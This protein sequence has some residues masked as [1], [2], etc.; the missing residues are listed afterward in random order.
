MGTTFLV[1]QA[2]PSDRRS[3]THVDE[4]HD[5]LGL[6]PHNLTNLSA[7]GGAPT[8]AVSQLLAIAPSSDTCADA[9][10]PSECT[11]TTASLAQI[12]IASF[13]RHSV[14][15]GLEQAALLSWMAFESAEWKYNRNHFPAPGR[16]GQGTRVMMMP[17]YVAEFASGFEELTD[18][19]TAAGGD[20]DRILD[21]VLGDEYSFAAAAWFYDTQCTQEVKEG[22]KT[23]GEQGW[24]EF[25]TGCVETTVTADRKGY[26]VR[27]CEALN[28]VVV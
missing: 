17:N 26:W 18:E 23:G 27:A 10:I 16:P 28:I 22:V 25:V 7:R 24:E 20:L 21:S 1:V 19:V 11:V 8:D 12:I 9:P 5:D 2:F 14:T 13:G 6:E 3:H 4:P 15:T